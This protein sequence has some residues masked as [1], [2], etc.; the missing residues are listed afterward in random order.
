MTGRDTSIDDLRATL[1][2]IV[3]GHHSSLAYTSFARFNPR[4]YLDATAPIVD[5]ARWVGFDFLENFNDVFFMSWMFLIGGL[6]VWSALE[7]KGAG[8]Y[9][10]ERLL[11]LGV[12]FACGVTVLVPL[13]YYPSAAME[14]GGVASYLAFWRQCLLRDGW[15]SGPLWFIWVLLAF[16][17]LAALGYRLRPRVPPVLTAVV[18][19][20]RQRP[21][22]LLAA[23]VAVSAAAFVPLLIVVGPG[24]WVTVGGPLWFQPSRIGLYAVYFGLGVVIG[25]VGI[26]RGPFAREAP[27]GRRWAAWAAA[28]AAVYTA[29]W[30]LPPMIRPVPRPLRGMVYG[31]VFAVSCATSGLAFLAFFR[32]FATRPRRIFDSLAA[33]AY[34]IYLVHYGFVVWLQYPL[35]PSTLAATAKFAIVASGATLASWATTAVLR[36]LPALRAILGA[37]PPPLA[38]VGR[39]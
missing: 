38:T 18:V 23:L 39:R 26:E 15:P 2:L 12:P 21:V 22:A 28:A 25:A 8:R 30:Y 37:P 24:R 10:R 17:L 33:N 6:F 36:R 20:W 31:L 1:T 9:A 11:R 27:L 35:V 29:L 13:W 5:P 32:R 3:V 14:E 19:R 4:S 7:R 34:G 16:N